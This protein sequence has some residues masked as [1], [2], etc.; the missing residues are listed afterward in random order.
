[1][2]PFSSPAFFVAKARFR[3]EVFGMGHGLG[4]RLIFNVLLTLSKLRHSY[5][6]MWHFGKNNDMENAHEI[7]K[8]KKSEDMS[9]C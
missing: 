3:G 2:S 8:T 1:M 9:H 6:L 7:M 5:T 4:R